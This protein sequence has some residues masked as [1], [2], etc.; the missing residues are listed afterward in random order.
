MDLPE[1]TEWDR[2][3]GTAASWCP[4]VHQKRINY[5]VYSM[6]MGFP[7]C[8]FPS[9]VSLR[10]K[11]TQLHIHNLDKKCIIPDSIFMCPMP[12]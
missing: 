2:A 4:S 7:S 1:N 9:S 3:E 5:T 10:N 6:D 11:Q 12:K 8:I